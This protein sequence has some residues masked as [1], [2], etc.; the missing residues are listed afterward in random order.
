VAFSAD[1][2]RL[3]A[4]NNVGKILVSTNSGA[5]WSSSNSLGYYINSLASSA[6]GLTLLTASSSI[7]RSYTSSN[8]GQAWMSNSVPN[9]GFWLAAAVSADGTRLA[10]AGSTAASGNGRWI[11]SSSDSGATWISNDVPR[12]GWQSLATSADG[13]LLFAASA[14]GGIWIRRTTPRPVLRP[15][16]STT[17]LTIG[18]VVPSASFVL[19]QNTDFI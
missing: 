6:D 16:L 3:A 18:Y 19:Q 11:Y 5:T 13:N 12:V 17:N 14:D 8:G 4:G 10:I 1:G 7:G 2:R 15:A 9:N